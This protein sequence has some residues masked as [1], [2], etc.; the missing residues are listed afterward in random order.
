MSTDYD[1]DFYTW[2]QRQAR[3]LAQRRFDE[4]DLENLIEEVESMGRSEQD[5][6][7]SH[8]H[9]LLW[10]LL[11]WQY[12]P[13][14]RGNSWRLTIKEQRRQVA[15]VLRKNPGLKASLDETMADAYETARL[16][17]A[18]E[19]DLNEALFPAVCPWGFEAIS[20]EDFWPE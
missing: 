3:L 7:E 19:T 9:V 15:K 17:A 20:D 18:R 4:L 16:S 14:R 2:T 1:T 12:Q 10:H 8:L 5:K 13:D 11:K 6:L